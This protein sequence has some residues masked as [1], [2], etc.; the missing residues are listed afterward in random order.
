MRLSATIPA[1][2]TSITAT[3]GPR[4]QIGDVSLNTGSHATGVY[5]VTIKEF[6][7][8][9]ALAFAQVS[10]LGNSGIAR[11]ESLVYTGNALAITVNTYAV[12]GTTATDKAF[13]LSVDAF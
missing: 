5:V 4:S 2:G 6:K 3:G 7:G 13:I 12:D 11:V 10:L 8:P 1:A 9:R